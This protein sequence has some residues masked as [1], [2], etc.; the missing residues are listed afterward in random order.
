MTGEKLPSWNLKDLYRG[1]NDPSIER[2]FKSSLKLASGFERRFSGKLKLNNLLEALRDYE[3]IQV[4][5][6]QPLLYANL[7]FAESCTPKARGPFLSFAKSRYTE[8]AQHLIFFEIE[9]GNLPTVG[10]LKLLKDKKFQSYKNYLS[11]LIRSKPHRLSQEVEKIL[12]E[13]SLSGRSAFVRLF[14]EELANKKFLFND[15]Q[16][17]GKKIKGKEKLLTEH[18]VLSRLYSPDRQQRKEAHRSLTQGLKD[19]ARRLTF[20]FNTLAHDKAIDDK[21]RKFP[22]PEESR[23]LENETTAKAV[24]AMTEV[25]QS[26]YREV[27]RFYEF[28]KNLLEVKELYD[29]DRYAPIGHS[30]VKIPYAKARELVLRAFYGF[31][32]ELGKACEEFFRKNWID[33]KDRPGKRGGAFC[34]FMT[35]DHHPYVFMNYSGSVR[36]VFTLAHELGHGVHAYF[37]REQN[38]LNFDTPLT[39]AE[40]A[41]VFAEM[42]LFEHLSKEMPTKEDLLSLY[43]GRVEG[44]FATVF[45]QT[46]MFQF[47]RDVHGAYREC[48]EL[49][50]ERINE[51]WRARQREMFGRS[52]TLTPEYDWWWSYIPHFVHTPFY[53]YAYSYGELLTLAL[54]SRYRSE[55]KAF[56]SRYTGMLA[57]GGS[58]P[59]EALFGPFGIDISKKSFWQGGLRVIREMVDRTLSI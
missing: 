21:L 39:V 53:V 38:Y 24:S 41:S 40:T 13:K 16:K 17:I 49:S 35:P 56:C 58:E 52:V 32:D 46:S 48:G 55:G 33:A 14:D 34:S 5:A 45:R 9:A 29:Y 59:P 54:Y 20:I 6:V 51:L 22:T 28:K 1:E 2:D 8:I 43:V 30:T 12:S 18:D 42:L 3:K 23:H 36:D 19:E 57:K 10:L 25:V 50:T 27:Q 11:K 26:G 4:R 31:S 47:E 7:L 15:S 37:M 44:M